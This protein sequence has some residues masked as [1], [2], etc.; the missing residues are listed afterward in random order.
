MLAFNNLSYFNFFD[1]NLSDIKLYDIISLYRS[2]IPLYLQFIIIPLIIILIKNNHTIEL[3]N[4]DIQHLLILKDKIKFLTS[5]NEE[6][7]IKNQ[8]LKK[9]ISERV[10]E[11]EIKN[12][13]I[14]KLSSEIKILSNRQIE[15]T[16]PFKEPKFGNG[17]LRQVNSFWPVSMCKESKSVYY[18]GVCNE[19]LQKWNKG[20]ICSK[21][22]Y[23]YKL[24]N[25]KR[26]NT[27]KYIT[28][29]IDEFCN[30][31]SLIKSTNKYNVFKCQGHTY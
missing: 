6:L 31:C 11:I 1:I 4:D 30:N 25:K 7:L 10:S 9:S 16:V 5:K 14:E 20:N 2:Y 17:L 21:N 18:H 15:K 28:Y 13:T 29:N 3:L 12:E 19:D 24:Q 8:S 26:R 23:E 22:I 27:D